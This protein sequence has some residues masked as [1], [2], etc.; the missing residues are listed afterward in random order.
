MKG[1]LKMYESNPE[2]YEKYVEAHPMNEDLVKIYDKA[3]GG[4]LNELYHVAKEYRRMEGLTPSEREALIK[5]VTLEINLYKHELLEQ[6]KAY[7]ME[8]D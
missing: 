7:G 3:V 8:P 4:D 5:P 1:M 2:Q 6:F